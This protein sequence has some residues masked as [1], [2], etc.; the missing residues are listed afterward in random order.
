[1][2]EGIAGDIKTSMDAFKA[3]GIPGV[4]DNVSVK[5]TIE[6]TGKVFN[7]GGTIV[8][9]I[10]ENMVGEGMKAVNQAGT[11]TMVNPHMELMMTGPQ[12]RTFAFSYTFAPRNKKELE[13]AHK[14]IKTFKYHMLPSLRGAGTTEHLLD[15][16]SQFEIRYMYKEKENV[17]IP[18]VSRCVLNSCNINYTPHEA[19]TTFKG[20]SKG[21]SP[22]IMTMTLS[23]TEMEVMTKNTVAMGY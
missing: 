18:R 12:F 15:M 13:S 2:A 23:F 4:M 9:T 19:F 1:L 7:A 5:D 11:N 14:I 22:N 10:V 17:Y 3:R 16:P 8:R 20:D 21:A 6:A